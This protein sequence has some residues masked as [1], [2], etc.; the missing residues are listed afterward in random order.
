M[1]ETALARV[2]IVLVRPL[3]PLNVGSVARVMKNMGLSQLVLVAP[4]CDRLGEE[5]R[6]MA[7]HAADILEAARE[8]AT[9]AEALEGCQLAIATTAR[10]RKLSL[11]LEEP[12]TALP[13]LLQQL[14][15]ALI[16]GPED[17]G[18]SNDDLKYA[19]RFLR[20]PTSDAYPALNLAQAV[21]VCC[22]E[23]FQY[24]RSQ[25]KQPGEQS[26][27]HSSSLAPL[28]V[29]EEF[30]GHLESVLLKIGY[31]YPH[32]AAA[33]MAKFRLLFNRAQLSTAEVAMLRGIFS[34]M[35]WFVS[36]Q[37][38][39]VADAKLSQERF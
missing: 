19:Q 31:L 20:I 35:E 22:Y 26:I 13:S 8:V 4:Q 29:A 27:P 10:D 9:V 14:P 18:L 34:Q 17:K 1:D 6:Q 30:Y 37:E 32:T 33:R 2:R 36:Q 7:I 38:N 23:L 21:T 39:V 3:G 15:S 12:R 16:F 24:Q 28:Q 25:E 11:E 5:A